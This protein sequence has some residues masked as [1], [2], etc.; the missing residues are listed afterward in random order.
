MTAED[1]SL[2][3]GSCEVIFHYFLM[4]KDNTESFCLC[5]LRTEDDGAVRL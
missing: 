5:D 2:G 4:I 1:V 3:F